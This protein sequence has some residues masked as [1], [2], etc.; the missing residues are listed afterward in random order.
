MN[1]KIASTIKIIKAIEPAL[2]PESN[3]GLKNTFGI[4]SPPTVPENPFTFKNIY[5]D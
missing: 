4:N 5:T 2:P 1:E 3:T